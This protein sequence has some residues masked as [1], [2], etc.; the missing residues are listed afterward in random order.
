M[1]AHEM[2][3]LPFEETFFS[4]CE[5]TEV[6]QAQSLLLCLSYIRNITS[7]EGYM[8]MTGKLGVNEELIMKPEAIYKLIGI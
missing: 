7:S 8:E 2:C 5:V 6:Y 3:N 1:F 4:K